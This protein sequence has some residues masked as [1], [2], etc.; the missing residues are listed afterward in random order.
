MN[1][2]EFGSLKL[3]KLRYRRGDEI[4]QP[5][6]GIDSSKKFGPPYLIFGNL[7]SLRKVVLNHTD[8][9]KSNE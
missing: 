8:A 1:E 7:K 4:I 9:L 6:C 3:L 2:E 5:F